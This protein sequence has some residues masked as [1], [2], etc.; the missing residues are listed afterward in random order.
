LIPL[1]RIRGLRSDFSDLSAVKLCDGLSQVP[2][3]DLPPAYRFLL[4]Q[5]HWQL[6]RILS[7]LGV[8]E[9]VDD[10]G[11][12]ED[13]ESEAAEDKL[14]AGACFAAWTGEQLN[15]GHTLHIILLIT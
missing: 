9:D 8:P 10:L 6:I 1:I 3:H 15:E 7:I 13:V 14:A 12:E 2:L 5:Y 4:H 11:I